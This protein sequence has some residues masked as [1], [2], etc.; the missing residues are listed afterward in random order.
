MASVSILAP[1]PLLHKKEDTMPCSVD[2]MMPNESEVLSKDLA[3]MVLHCR[4]HQVLSFDGEDLAELD[5]VK[6]SQDYYG[7]T[8]IS[9]DMARLQ[10]KS[11]KAAG[12]DW[13]YDGKGSPAHA[14]INPRQR[15][16]QEA[17]TPGTRNERIAASCLEFVDSTGFCLWLLSPFAYRVHRGLPHTEK[18]S[19]SMWHKPIQHQK[20]QSMPNSRPIISQRSTN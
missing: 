13:I 2:H 8:H 14:G 12:P 16:A 11:L 19:Q 5:V 10:C 18:L 15:M 6:A 3:K 4:D 17:P 7:N 1:R 20:C 9:N